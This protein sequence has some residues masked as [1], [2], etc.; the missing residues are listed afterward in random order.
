MHFTKFGKYEIIRKLSRSLTDVYLAL[1]TE[2]D[3]RV[4]LKLIEDA[5]DDFTQVVIEAE[6]RGA[7]IQKALHETDPRILAIYEYGQEQ[8]CFF[9]SMEYFEGKTLAQLVGENGRMRAK[10]AARYAAEICSQLKSLHSFVSDLKG[11]QTAVVHGD[12]KPSN[13]QIGPSDELRLLDFG[14]AKVITYTH[15]LTHHNLGSP[16]YCSPERLSKGQVDPHSD[17]WAAGV[18]LYEMLAGAPPYQAE[19]TRKLENLIQSRRPLRAL[20]EDC[21]PGLRAIVGK[22]L[23]SDIGRRYQSAHEFEQD[24][25]SYLDGLPTVADLD[26][27]FWDANATIEKYPARQ[28]FADA[29]ASKSTVFRKPLSIVKLPRSDFPSLGMALGAGLLAGFLLMIP[30]A[31]IYRLQQAMEPLREQKDYAHVSPSRLTADWN[32]YRHL[33][34]SNRLLKP[35]ARS[36]SVEKRFRL[37]LVAAADNILDSYRNSSDGQLSDFDWAKAQQCLRYARVIDGSD[38]DVRG[39]L[40]LVE[41]LLNLQEHPQLPEAFRSVV[42]FR[43]AASLMPRSADPHLALARVYIYAYRNVAL[44]AGELH[45]AEQL[46]KQ[47]GPRELEQEADG[48]RF[49]TEWDLLRAKY[50]IP[51]QGKN[52]WLD[53]A[54][55][56]LERARSLYEPIAGFSDVNANLER[57]YQFRTEQARL[58][59]DEAPL[60]LKGVLARRYARS[61]QW[62]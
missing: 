42:Q 25:R 17:L 19:N 22:S 3:R 15:N 62:P 58:R 52:K 1:D 35:L 59:L 2:Q 53:R 23:A 8:N 28:D 44:A 29:T 26:Q 36:A 37:N 4:V 55:E 56:D 49:R 30:L 11:R 60:V 51:Q 33:E 9:V 31:N 5:R 32:S 47:L 46:G 10:V 57:L 18:T 38:T 54:H 20:P 21:P 24:L 41:G 27:N 13:I 48:Y 45:Q 6:R 16:S 12:I 7:S 14:I 34:E 40:A 43:E 61:R 50:A 39:K